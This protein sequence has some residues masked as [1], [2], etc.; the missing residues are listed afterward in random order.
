[1]EQGQQVRSQRPRHGRGQGGRH[2]C[3]RLHHLYGATHEQPLVLIKDVEVGMP[4]TVE[5]VQKAMASLHK[6]CAESR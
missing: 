6:K 3:I 1:M 2:G 5:G 4:W